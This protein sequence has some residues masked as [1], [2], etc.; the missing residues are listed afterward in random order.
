M[1][2][3]LERYEDALGAFQSAAKLDPKDWRAF[4]NIGSLSGRLGRH[5]EALNAFRLT[6]QARPE[7]TAM[8][9][10]AWGSMGQEAAALD[11]HADAVS[12]WKRALEIDADYFDKYPYH[13]TAYRASLSKV[14]SPATP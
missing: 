13:Q 3:Q 14:Q 6:V 2:Q 1:L 5:V 4:L 7:D 9:A 11:K 12:Y 10:F 8:L